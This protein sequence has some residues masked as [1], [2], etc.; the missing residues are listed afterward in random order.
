MSAA[1]IDMLISPPSV[2]EKSV[3]WNRFENTTRKIYRALILILENKVP[4]ERVKATGI[5][6]LEVACIVLILVASRSVIFENWYYSTSLKLSLLATL[7]F[8]DKRLAA[9][10]TLLLGETTLTGKDSF[11]VKLSM[12]LPALSDK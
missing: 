6:D 9:G 10:A 12:A 2:I 11:A 4:F 8:P 1:E 7:G 3:L 5:D